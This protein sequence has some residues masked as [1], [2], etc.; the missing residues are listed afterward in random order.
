MR[1][2]RFF[3]AL[4]LVAALAPG[5]FVRSPQVLYSLE[6]EVTFDPLPVTEVRSGPFTLEQA[7]V[8]AG[9]P[10]GLGGFSALVTLDGGR[11]LA[12]TDGGWRLEFSRPDRRDPN[13]LV[14]VLGPPMSEDKFARD[15]ESLTRDPETGL[16]WGAYEMSNSLARFS[17]ARKMEKRAQPDEIG[18][19]GDNSG[20]EALVR[21]SDGRFL[22]IEER[23]SGWNSARHR[24]VVFA[25]DPTEGG[26]SQRLKFQGI[27]GYRPVDMT[28]LDGGRALVLFR[29]LR[30]SVPPAFASAIGILDMDHRAEDGS[31]LVREL[32]RL[33]SPFPFEN[34]EGMALTRDEDGRHLWLISD[35]NF[36]QY[37][38]TL[39]LKLRWHEDVADSE[40][41]RQKARD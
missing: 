21:F 18:D 6:G 27:A 9:E 23:E 25:G 3:L 40:P 22:V 15:L 26:P 34:Y 28:P 37:Q 17:V 41:A 1:K 4:C 10:R 13:P 30:F 16:I 2:G 35:D 19:W 32:T 7:W 12:G 5:T 14:A 11:F 39:L 31:L 20:P 29:D 24:A 36:M 38:R 33:Q 8:I